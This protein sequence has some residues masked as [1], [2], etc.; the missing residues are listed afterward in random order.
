M[1]VAATS[2]LPIDIDEVP[3]AEAGPAWQRRGDGRRIVLRP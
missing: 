2:D 3:L 1:A